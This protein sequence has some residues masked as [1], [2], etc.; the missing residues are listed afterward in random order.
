MTIKQLTRQFFFLCIVLLTTALTACNDSNDDNDKPEQLNTDTYS[1]D[2]S[3]TNN[4]PS[5]NSTATA[6]ANFTLN[7]E[8]GALSG[9]VTVSNLNDATMSHIHAG[10]AGSNGSA[11]VTLEANDDN[12]VFSVPDNTV[13]D[14]NQMEALLK[15]MYYVNVHSPTYPAGE[16]RGQ[17]LHSTI[18]TYSLNLDGSQEVPAVTTTASATAALTLNSISG[19]LNGTVTVSDLS[20]TTAAHIH[21]GFAG[22]NGSA[23]VPLEANDDNTVFSVPDNTTLDSSQMDALMKGM[24][25]I[26]VHSTSNP[27]G[28]IRG[29]ILPSTIKTYWTTLDGDQEVP[30]VTTTASATAALT[31]DSTTGALYGT[32]SVND[33]SDTTAAH[34]HT[35]F[36]G[37]NGSALVPFEANDDSTVFSVPDNTVLDSNQ[38]EALLKGM[39]YINVHSTTNPAGEIRGQIIPN[40]INVYWFNLSGDQEVPAVTTTATG[41]GAITINKQTGDLFGSIMTSGVDDATSAHI[42]EGDSGVNGGV[43]ITLV[44]DSS[45]LS[46]WNVPAGANISTTLSNFLN[47]GHY[48]NLHTPANSTGEI[49]GQIE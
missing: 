19:A 2:L 8:S 35:G 46:L 28:E 11:V 9:S 15:G 41:T 27:G 42:H 13:L 18:K 34:I 30:A 12:T 44:Q 20:D 33:L 43:A 4:V 21:T 5:N 26:N 37:S 16:I 23:L 6:Q 47:G 3:A 29:Q 24:Y 45:E 22:S 38:M 17:I 14:S 25:Y 39:Y 40:D 32:V 1:V 49:R 10:F 36:A 31:L 7:K 48:V